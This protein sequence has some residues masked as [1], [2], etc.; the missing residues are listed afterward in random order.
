MGQQV[1]A[2]RHAKVRDP[3]TM[4]PATE[5]C[6]TRRGKDARKIK[7]HKDTGSAYHLLQTLLSAYIH[8]DNSETYR[9][10]SAYILH[11]YIHSYCT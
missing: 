4:F 3:E 1:V 9:F 2:G 10:K 7:K 11:I 5:N 6:E 8:S